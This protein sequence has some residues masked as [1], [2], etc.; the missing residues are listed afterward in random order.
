[1]PQPGRTGLSVS[2][3]ALLAAAVGVAASRKEPVLAEEAAPWTR[4]D[5][6]RL[7]KDDFGVAV[8]EGAIYAIGG[9]TGS[10][11]NALKD[12]GRYDPVEDRWDRADPM[13]MPLRSVRS[14]LLGG[15]VHVVGGVSQSGTSAAV[16]HFEP[17]TQRWSTGV[18]MPSPRYGVGLA[19][20]GD[21][22][23]AFGGFYEGIALSLVQRFDPVSE[24]WDDL[25]PM[26]TPR[27]HLTTAVLD[28]V[29][30][31]IGGAAG[32]GS[33]DAVE[34]YDPVTDTWT[35]APPLPIPMSN[36][37]AALVGED[38]H[39]LWHEV[40]LAGDPRIGEYAS[41]PEMPTPRH[42]HGA[43]TI[44]G[45]VITFGGCHKNLYD[46]DVTETYRP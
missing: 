2:R 3:R 40:H 31:A 14:A 44:D 22:L 39:L 25:A 36:F 4:G 20:V 6:M 27:T 13:P 35:L 15:I 18:P 26:P 10:R 38:L 33:L 21:A 29:V 11:G 42:G 23:Y 12:V 16:H 9:M 17:D 32:R 8:V 28:G 41:L 30:V 7:P 1:M 45:R 5:P 37:A 19:V 24:R 46:L 34:L 43:A